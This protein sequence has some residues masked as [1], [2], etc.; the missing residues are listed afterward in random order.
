ME[1]RKV[2]SL[3]IK[4]FEEKNIRYGLIGGFALIAHGIPRTTV[5]ID[6]LVDKRDLDK[7]D[8]IMQ[9]MGYKLI[10]RTENVSQYIGSDISLG[11]VDFLHAFRKYSKKMLERMQDIKLE[12]IEAKVLSPED[13]IGLKV[14]A[15]AN[16]PDRKYKE[17]AD[18]SAI[19]KN[20]REKINWELLKEYFRL[21]NLEEEF[22]TLKKRYG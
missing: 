4:S 5:D 21:F 6:F 3:L 1:F 14:Q 10:F 19:I 13:I 8:K 2:L 12:D 20:F 16:N 15:I 11:E 22:Y 9:D 18:I 17:L 7:L